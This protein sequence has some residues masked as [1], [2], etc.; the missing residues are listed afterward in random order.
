[1]AVGRVITPLLPLVLWGSYLSLLNAGGWER[2]Y[3]WDWL[4][5]EVGFLVIFL[6]PITPLFSSP[7]CSSAHVSDT[8]ATVILLLRATAFRLLFGA[9]MSKLGGSSSA[10]WLQLSCTSTH[11]FTQPMPNPLSWYAHMLPASIHSLEVRH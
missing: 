7:A 8:P 4:T 3:G 9:G 2:N 6:Y 1:M 10:C 11:Y 5:L